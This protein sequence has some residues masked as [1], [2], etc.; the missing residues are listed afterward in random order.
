MKALCSDD[1][2]FWFFAGAVVSWVV[3]NNFVM[4]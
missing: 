1:S 4:G 2:V 3:S